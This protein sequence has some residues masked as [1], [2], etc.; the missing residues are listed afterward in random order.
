MRSAYSGRAAAFEKKGDYD[1]A[2]AD[3]NMLVFSYAVELDAAD[4]KADDYSDLLQEAIKAYRARAACLQMK[5]DSAAA[6]RD[7]KR[8]EKLEARGKKTAEKPKDEKPQPTGR[9][10]VRNDWGQPLTLF[11]AGA[12]YTLQ[13]GETKTLTTPVGSFPYEMQAGPYRV[14]ERME[15]GRSYSLASPP[16]GS[17]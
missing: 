12:S 3:Y 17:P 13:A 8:A 11:I 9:V 2:G 1:R 16:S 6:L 4:P 14:E 5:G 7:V 15:S 10:T